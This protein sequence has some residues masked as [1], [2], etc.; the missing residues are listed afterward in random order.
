MA[1]GV[2][3]GEGHGGAHRR[4]Q[5]EGVELQVLLGHAIGPVEA[6][7]PRPRPGLGVVGHHGV[8]DGLALGV[9]HH[10]LQIGRAGARRHQRNEHRQ[11]QTP[12]G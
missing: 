12:H 1:D 2:A 3:V 7:G 4:H 5:H 9:V 6:D 10:D 11:D 8:A